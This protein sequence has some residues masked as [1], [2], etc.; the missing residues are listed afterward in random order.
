MKKRILFFASVIF[1]VFLAEAKA[2]GGL[3]GKEVASLMP[4][5][6]S[7][8]P[9]LNP[10]AQL[11]STHY[12]IHLDVTDFAS[13]SL[14]GNTHI[15]MHT[16]P[17]S[18]S[19]VNLDLIDL[20][21]DSVFQGDIKLDLF[22]QTDTSLLFT[23]VQAA[24]VN[25]DFDVNIY[26]HGVPFHEGWGG[27]H[28]SGTYCFNLGVGFESI[29][30]NLGRAWFPGLDNFTD[31]ATYDFF[32][33]VEDPKK[34]ICGGTLAGIQNVGNNKRE[35]HWIIE[36]PIPTYL[37]SVAVGEYAEIS[38][39]YNGVEAD[40]PI[41]IFVRPQDSSKVES[42]FVNLK[43]IL[44]I[45]ETH[46][47]PYP[48]ERIGYVGTSLGAMEHVM[49][50][51]Y[52]HSAIDGTT[53][54][55]W[56]YAHELFHMW[57]G[58]N[59]TCSSAED[60]W[61]NEGW[62]TYS[63]ALFQ[64]FLYD[65]KQQYLDY[66]KVNQRKTMQYSHTSGGDGSYF[67][68]NQIPQEVTY[69]MCA[70][71][72]GSVVAHSLRGYL[73]DD[74]FFDAMKDYQSYFKYQSASSYDMEQRMSSFTGIDMHPFFDNWVYHSGT[75]HYSIDSVVVE[76]NG[77]SYLA[78]VFVRQK[79][80][81]VDFT[82]DNNKMYIDFI[83]DDW[84]VYTDTLFFSGKTGAAQFT[85]PFMP[86]MFVSDYYDRMFDA[87]INYNRVVKESGLE[88]FFGTFFQLETENIVDS[89]LF[90]IEHHWVAPDTLKTPVQGLRIS[91]YHYWSIDG[92]FEP[93]FL[94]QGRF[95]YS[96]AGHMDNTLILSEADSVVLLYR[97]D[98]TQDWTFTDAERIGYWFA[99]TLLLD[100]IQKG[101]YCLAVLDDTYVK[102]K[103]KGPSIS[104]IQVYPNPSND[105]VNVVSQKKGNVS[106]F[107]LSGQ[108]FEKK[109]ISSGDSL[110]LDISTLKNGSYFILFQSNEGEKQSV[111]IVKK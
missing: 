106:L 18:I 6:T 43:N 83:K 11:S 88:N 105:Y 65:N 28:W 67:P 44:N 61:L 84:S 37:A 56:W 5:S 100:D 13:H 98:A 55:D 23:M 26:Y 52:P 19:V 12:D 8:L 64:E 63:E 94:A 68:L 99:G 15:Q 42:T 9:A 77:G 91:D 30:H 1:G 69:G 111:P 36:H 109:D 80:K 57:F 34:A 21:V 45:F 85:L 81:G 87:R 10:K 20:T 73:G 62:A 7:L 41:L 17:N 82:G 38:D 32:I 95:S 72:K 59:V 53:S 47:G 33:T 46:F 78:S 54:N 108:M 60:M 14:A 102:T 107:S 50:I 79:H 101:E 93:E 40:I 66:L 70:Y 16:D 97:P 25:G 76:E 58:D 90:R 29:P 96:I 31:R 75:P 74:L 49:N 89:I 92:I 51:A 48:W 71:K 39:V 104:Y 4:A 103:E 27:F 110:R 86:H 2:D 22:T 3:I 24:G 35:Y